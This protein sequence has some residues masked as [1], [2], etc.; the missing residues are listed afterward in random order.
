MKGNKSEGTKPETALLDRLKTFPKKFGGASHVRVSDLLDL[1]GNRMTVDYAFAPLKVAVEMRG[2]YWHGCPEHYTP[3]AS[4]EEYWHPKIERNRE[5][6]A[7][8]YALFTDAGWTL[9]EIWE[10]DVNDDLDRCVKQVRAAINKELDCRRAEKWGGVPDGWSPRITRRV[11][12][13]FDPLYEPVA[14]RRAYKPWMMEAD[15]WCA[16]PKMNGHRMTLHFLEDRVVAMSRH[17]SRKTGLKVDNSENVPHLTGMPVPGL[18]YTILDGE[19]VTGDDK[20]WT[21][22]SIMGCLP[23]KAVRRQEEQG[24]VR[25]HA[26]GMPMFRGNDLHGIPDEKMR[27]LLLWVWDLFLMPL[28]PWMSPLPRAYTTA[29]KELMLHRE[30]DRGGE[31]IILKYLDGG[32]NRRSWAKVKRSETYDCVIM[33]WNDATPMTKK[34]NG[35]VS[36]SRLHLNGWIGS[37]VLGQYRQGHLVK[38]CDCSGMDDATRAEISFDPASFIGRVV[39]VRAQERTPDGKLLSPRFIRWRPDKNPTQCDIGQTG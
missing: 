13:D 32:Y 8:K 23:A 39:E 10:H 7:E 37:L 18:S 38:V 25:F 31:G 2:C 9:L 11:S 5:R 15:R 20:A 36:P 35:D 22:T 12:K 30:W 19:I 14:A 3:P 21:A 34:V 28:H 29:E 1:P 17:T 24:F 4:N 27:A 33:G 16:E 26:F 6:D